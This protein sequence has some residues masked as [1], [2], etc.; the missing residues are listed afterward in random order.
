M[1]S[2]GPAGQQNACS[3]TQPRSTMSNWIHHGLALLGDAQRT[4]FRDIKRLDPED[5]Q[6]ADELEGGERAA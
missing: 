3:C 5:L 4:R 1:H 2:P 6:E